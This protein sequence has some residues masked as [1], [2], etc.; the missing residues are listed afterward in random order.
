M[1]ARG[2]Y[3]CDYL[4]IGGGSAGCVLASRLS[5]VPTVRVTLVEAGQDTEP[6]A[7]RDAR[8]RT[9][10]DSRFLWP[11]LS[12]EYSQTG[13]GPL[14]FGQ[15]KIIGG[16][17]AI[18]GMHAQR[19]LPA[20]YEEWNSFGIQGWGW[21]DVL[22]YFK[23]LE[24]DCDFDDEQHGKS[25]P[26][27][28]QRVPSKDWSGLTKAVA[29]VYERRGVH[30]IADLN[31]Q[32][33]DGYG[34]VPVNMI[35]RHR[36]STAA[37]YL[38]PEVRKRP[39][40]RIE[41]G[42][43][44]SRLLFDGTEVV[45]AL[46]GEGDQA[47]TIRSRETIISGGALHSP[48]IL[49][50]SGIGPSDPL[51]AAGIPVVKE[52]PGVGANLLN[53]PMLIVGAHLRSAG[54]QRPHVHPPC[55]VVVRYSSGLPGVAE[56]D[57]VLNVWER[58]PN[59]LERDPLGRQVA[60]LMFIINKVYSRGSVTLAPNGALDVRFNLLQDRRDL[61]R[62]VDGLHALAQLVEEPEVA[63]IVD[64]AF[65]PAMTPLALRMMQDNWKAK[66]LS[67][68]GAAAFATR[69][70]ARR[71]AFEMAGTPISNVISSGKDRI[72]RTVLM[73]ALP[74]GH[75][76]GTCRMGSVHD[77]E[78]VVDSSCRVIG[79]N[80]LRVV[81]ASIFPTLMAAGTNLPVIMAAEKIVDMIRQEY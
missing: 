42:T 39:N 3:D 46:V 5:E 47:R 15:A 7:I 13:I 75:V 35:G 8:F 18:N 65:L 61:R 28:L 45:G 24:T 68:V 69:G 23:R 6:V 10:N 44:V 16:G 31:G 70:F 81:D 11:G 63:R 43:A 1:S 30:A 49:L 71:K 54:R 29:T 76:A 14:P 37:A 20:D 55:P 12:A 36:L 17:S 78:A 59:N 27:R 33:G 34:S 74:G 79:L 26:F 53:H 2:P 19:G 38:T 64:G 41:T 66:A 80:G 72:E 52:L 77:P 60:N 25:G 21:A 40:L 48:A 9:L 58:T 62:M 22:P 56:T 73:S 50:R 4:V 32:D 51:R 57:V 67:L